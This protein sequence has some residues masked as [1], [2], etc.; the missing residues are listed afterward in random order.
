MAQAEQIAT[1][2]ATLQATETHLRDEHLKTHE[3]YAE[4]LSKPALAREED[5]RTIAALEET[6]KRYE[7]KM[8]EDRKKLEQAEKWEEEVKE[9]MRDDG[10]GGEKTAVEGI[11]VTQ[12]GRGPGAGFCVISTFPSCSFPFLFEIIANV[13]IV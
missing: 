12:W 3:K 5:I 6:V 11:P 10:K 4:L 9:Y 2:Q 7:S 13:W 1:L 8:D